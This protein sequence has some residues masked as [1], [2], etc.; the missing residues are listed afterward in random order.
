MAHRAAKPT[1]YPAYPS[2][3]IS[4]IREMFLKSTRKNA[5][6]AALQHKKDGCWVPIT[7][8]ELRGEVELVSCGLAN[9]GLQPITGKLAIVGDNRPEWAISYLAAAC[10]GIACVPIDKDLKETEV[11]NILCLSGAQALIGD[12]K[13]MEMILTIR[14][15]LP[16]L[17]AIVNM[18]QKLAV[19]GV[20]SFSELRRKGED[21]RAAGKN[22]FEER[23]VSSDHLLSIL[24]TSGTM[25][26]PKGV[27]LTHGNVASNLVDAL[28]WVDLRSEDRFLS[29][30]PIHH[31]YECTVGFLLALHLGATTS[32][33]ENL[34][35][36]V[37]N[38]AETRTTAVLGVP[39]LWH[40]IYK[41]IEAG[42]A[43]K[44]QWKV[45]AA[46]KLAAFS[47]KILGLSI[48]RLLFARVHA[49]FGGNLRILISGGAA[50][51]P[52]VS[53]GFRELG[54][55]FLQGYGLTESAPLVAVNRNGA[56][57]DDS[58]GIPIPSGEVMIAEDG[59][60]LA[61]G[62]NIMKGYYN[63]PDATRDALEGGWLH[64]GD[65]GYIDDEGFLYIRG[66]KKSV[67]VTPAGKKIYPEE[68][69]AEILKSPFISECIVCGQ[70][71][72]TPGKEDVIEAIVV[73]DKE[74][75]AFDGINQPAIEE[76]LQKE[77]RERCRKLA[78]FKRVTKVTVRH[79]ELEKTTTRKIKRYLYAGKRAATDGR[80]SRR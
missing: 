56:F 31:S 15:K 39:L 19:D 36:I 29:V 23:T 46:K 67:I 21:R 10:T 34:R 7:Y 6:K 1:I 28:R 42:M 26:N 72:D 70:N 51:D 35:R 11:Y 16:E 3:R 52:A 32:Y 41:K 77:V 37:E 48:R 75:P 63:N 76:L 33:A 71:D 14:S 62:P 44:G 61:R 4:D 5:K 38:M 78:S 59:E 40:A 53:R 13:H 54:I 22:D 79:E 57:K 74:N 17:A 30:L 24:F 64:T 45:N 8:E 49:K 68:V 50:V 80:E 55:A 65:L 9:L 60:I 27:M 69:E 47:E 66:R 58:A 2:E 43:E 18:D 73:P 25:G 12:D 20:I